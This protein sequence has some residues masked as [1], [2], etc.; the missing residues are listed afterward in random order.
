MGYGVIVKYSCDMQGCTKEETVT[1]TNLPSQI[2]W[3]LSPAFLGG[4]TERRT[5]KGPDRYLCE[6]C[7]KKIGLVAGVMGA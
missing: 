5:S 1:D 6:N 4:R 3:Q 7:A 2:W